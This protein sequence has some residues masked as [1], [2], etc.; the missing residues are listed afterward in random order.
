MDLKGKKF[1]VIGGAGFIGSHVVDQL[2]QEDVAEV[3]IYDNFFR[4]RMDNIERALEDPRCRLFEHGGDILYPDILSKAMEGM[5][6]VFH[7]AALWILQCH[8]YP[9]TAMDVNVQGTFNVIEACIKNNI[10][11][12]VYSSSA[13]VYG[14]ALEL[15]MT[16]DHPYNNF[17][18][19]GASKIAGEHF[20]KSLGDR[21]GFDWVG[22][23]Y[24]NVYGPRQDYTGAY[25]AVMHKILDRIDK[26]ERPQVYGDGS[27]QYDFI[28]V[29]DIAR[30]NILSMKSEA[31][32]ECYNV[33]RGIGT[34]IKELTDTLIKLT[35]T[36]LEIEYKEAGLTFVTNRIGCPKKAAKDIGFEWT[37]DLDEG[38]KRLI[39]WR[40]SDIAA[41]ESRRKQVKGVGHDNR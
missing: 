10:K 28:A 32:G 38:M 31:T 17:T 35:G 33:G 1:L 25:I 22:L 18:F 23:R 26:G 41:L 11:K 5:D 40:K 9:R 13:S 30:A 34:S 3:V 36:D 6:G 39:D 12:V 37:I 14:N 15:P 29:E 8:E 27:Q 24:M 20:F 4:G 19:Y 21:Y 2:L 16:E 7:L